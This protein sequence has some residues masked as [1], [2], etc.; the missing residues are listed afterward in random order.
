MNGACGESLAADPTGV[1]LYQANLRVY[2]LL[3]YGVEVQ[4]AAGRPF[5]TVHLIDW[6]QPERNDFALAEEVTLKGGYERRPDVVLYVNGIAVTVIELKRSSIEI[7]DGARQLITNQEEIFNL[8]FFA[9]AQ[10][11][12]AGSDSQGLRFGTATTREEFF[13]EWKAPPLPEGA[14]VP[15]GAHLDRPLADLCSK[16]RLLE[17]IRNFVIFDNGVKMVPR[18]HQFAGVKAAQERIRRRE[19]GVIRHTQGSGKSIL[20]VLLAK[21]LL[22][23]DPAARILVVTDRDELDKQI[24]GV[25]KNAGVV[26]RGLAFPADHQPRRVRRKAWRRRAAAPVRTD[27]QVRSRRPEGPAA[28]SPRPLLCLRRRMPPHPGRRHE[29]ADE[30]LA[31]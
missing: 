29:Q 16:A 2:K 12:L 17:L 20:M 31:Q 4:I 8:P 28:A 7:A 9:T 26:G 30:A 5:D 22:E 19:G 10:L 15:A 11:L 14:P 1:A 21:W 3:R 13:V 6:E 24:E 18:H 23:H 25:M 27:P